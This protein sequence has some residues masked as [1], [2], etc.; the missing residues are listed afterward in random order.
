MKNAIV[1]TGLTICSF[2]TALPAA[3][4]ED[5]GLRSVFAEGTGNRALGLGGAFVALADDASAPAWNPAGLTRLLRYELQASHTGYYDL[6][7]SEQHL[8]IA[9]PSW[10]W[11]NFGLGIRQYSVSGIEQRD[12]FNVLQS[13]ELSRNEQEFSLSYAQALTP[14]WSMGFTGKLRRLSFGSYTA[15]GVGLDLGVIGRPLASFGKA[16]GW[17]RGL[18]IGLAIRNVIEPTLT[19]VKDPVA[20][21][22]GL[23]LG[24]AQTIALGGGRG[25][26]LVA[27]LEKTRDMDLRFHGGME[28]RAHS[29]LALRGGLN[30]RGY[31]MGAGINY[32]RARFDYV[33]EANP[34]D[35]VH[36]MGIS[37]A[38]GATV[39]ERR[40]LARAEAEAA[41]QNRMAVAFAAKQEERVK[42]LLAEASSRHA[43]G[44]YDE[45]LDLLETAAALEPDDE[46]I[47]SFK[48]LCL[49]KK[50]K[51]LE[52]DG[53]YLE[54][55][56]LYSRLLEIDAEH[57][58]AGSR[59][60]Y[61]RRM[62]DEQAARSEERGRQFA[63]AMDAFIADE[64]ATALAGFTR[65]VVLD[66]NDAEAAAMRE[67]TQ[68]LIGRRIE[69]LVDESGGLAKAG[70]F[71]QA[72]DALARGD[73]LQP[74]TK[75][76]TRARFLVEQMQREA[77]AMRTAQATA[78][79]A[80]DEMP[81]LVVPSP[82]LELDPEA[83]QELEDLYRRGLAAIEDERADEALRYWEIVWSRDPGFERVSEHL[84]QEYTLRGMQHFASRE[85][86]E[87]IENWEAALR[88]DP[89]DERTNSYL[90]RARERQTRSHAISNGGR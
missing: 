65:V 40:S 16:S 12:E 17:Q 54:A 47:P 10:R 64:L 87:A 42:E 81:A 39:H 15:Q 38:F 24:L 58:K 3:G 20:D 5:A 62:G 89:N 78:E 48:V 23:R 61:C 21:P 29:L 73:R 83:R 85:L 25:L 19:L 46:R 14:T 36:R 63:A 8:Y 22:T 51:L 75:A 35:D 59:L 72:L 27:D 1:L 74:G 77:L 37:Y 49:W 13:E 66:A 2:L 33:F 53:N 57:A 52:A 84:K 4:S 31:S 11:G 55:S 50:A 9:V 70:R 56:L 7:L 45:A 44:E 79:A 67:R 26:L 88:V 60:T 6:G 68:S 90:E 41:L 86:G 28:F 32:R 43:E 71:E 69:S 18:N 76:V 82:A 30:T 34:L 80:A